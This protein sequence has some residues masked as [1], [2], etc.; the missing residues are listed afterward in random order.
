MKEERKLNKD[1]CVA[2]VIVVLSFVLFLA[3]VVP[4][5]YYLQRDISSLRRY[6][7]RAA[8]RVYEVNLQ[9]H[10]G[11]LDI[12]NNYQHV[13]GDSIAELNYDSANIIS[14]NTVARINSVAESNLNKSLLVDLTAVDSITQKFL[15]EKDIHL[16]VYSEILNPD[17]KEIFSTTADGQNHYYSITSK[18]IPIDE[19][20]TKVLRLV[21]VNPFFNYYR[22]L[23]ICGLLSLVS[24]LALG[25]SVYYIRRRLVE[26]RE[27]IE[28]KNDIFS[29][30]S[31]EYRKPLTILKMTIS[32]LD[33]DK[34][35]AVEEKRERYFKKAYGE[36]DKM[37]GQTDVILS[38]SRDDKGAFELN[39][40]LFDLAQVASIAV[41]RCQDTEGFELPGSEDSEDTEENLE[42]P[43]E[44]RLTIVLE[45]QLE[46]KMF[47]GDRDHVE[48]IFTNLIDNAVKYSIPPISIKIKLYEDNKNV[49][50]SVKD[51]GIGIAKEDIPYIFDRYS[52]I[53]QTKVKSKG[54]GIGLNYVKRIVG[55]HNGEIKTYSAIGQGTEFVIRLPR[56]EESINRS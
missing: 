50:L 18:N 42:L 49:Y 32:T 54:H 5:C 11:I 28:L 7:N 45:D 31:H 16:S 21:V 38:M 9:N 1:I 10:D 48:H 27:M 6:I 46:N 56:Q 34:L 17:T 20:S 29:D 25:Y 19:E 24:L 22:I 3:Q 8:D 44:P 12:T 35:F 26:Q 4:F 41:E 47:Y 52:R 51:N 13:I 33:N 14:S 39:N 23:L 15:T 40:S 55:K 36:I 2:R 53:K 37:H 43:K 30:L